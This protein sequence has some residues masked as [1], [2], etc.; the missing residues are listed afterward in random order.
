M[1]D[2]DDDLSICAICKMCCAISKFNLTLTLQPSGAAHFANCAQTHK[3]AQHCTR[4]CILTYRSWSDSQMS[5]KMQVKCA[6]GIRN[7]SIITA[8]H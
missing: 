2:D 7:N 4:C 5:I 1:S 6:Y 8:S 3:L